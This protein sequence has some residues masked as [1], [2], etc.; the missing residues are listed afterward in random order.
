MPGRLIAARASDERGVALIVTLFLMAALSALAASLMY[1]SQTETYS[2]M[3]YTMMSQARYAGES[4]IEKTVNWLLNSYTLPGSTGSDLTSNYNMTNSPVTC[5]S[6]CTTTT[7]TCS[8]TPG[9]TPSGPCVVLSAVTGVN[10]NY[11]VSATA[12]SFASAGTGTLTSG[13]APIGYSAYAVL[14]SMQSVG[15]TVVQTWSIVSNGTVSGARTGQVQVISTLETPM[16]G[17]TG[18]GY[19]AFATGSGCGAITFSGSASTN[20]YDSSKLGTASYWSGGVVGSGHPV[21]NTTSNANVGTNGNLTDSG[22]TTINGKLYTPRTGVGTCNN[23]G[24]GVAGDADTQ[25][26]SATVTGGL[27][28]LATTWYPTT[29]AAPVPTAPTTTQS[30]SH[31]TGCGSIT[32]CSLPSGSGSPNIL[33]IT[34]GT[35]VGTA[36]LLGNVT[37]SSDVVLHLGAAG[38]CSPACYYTI[39]SLAISGGASLVIDGGPVIINIAGNSVTGS[40]KAFDLSGGGV[41]NSTFV[42]SNLQINYAGTQP[43]NASGGTSN[44]A[45]IDA[46]NA[47]ATLSGGADFY[48]AILA[49]TLTDSGGTAIHYDQQLNSMYSTQSTGNPL[50]TSFSWKKY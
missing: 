36:T 44:A 37:L 12:T 16:I 32:Q 33:K 8:Y 28:Q 41:A 3:N 1:L 11:P 15:T 18:N 14:M 45:L 7:G 31:N 21:V 20:S 26:G 38:G 29:P 50:L 34:G 2:T 40:N 35:G 5:S 10:S 23:G 42:P 43:V 17:V 46:P 9:G 4:G 47:P 22:G 39:N 13:S 6:G 27:V 19:A 25:S 24:G 49:A 30:F 48:G